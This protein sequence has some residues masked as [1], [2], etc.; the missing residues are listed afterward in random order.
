MKNFLLLVERHK[1]LADICIKLAGLLATFIGASFVA[2]KYFADRKQTRLQTEL[3]LRREAY[4]NLFT[5]IPLQ[6]AE[7]AKL[8]M[9]QDQTINPVPEWFTALGRLHLLANEEALKCVISRTAK[10]HLG[11]FELSKLKRTALNTDAFKAILETQGATEHMMENATRERVQAWENLWAM[12]R[13]VM[14]D[15]NAN[16][17][18][19]VCLARGEI[20]LNSKI[21]DVISAMEEDQEL[22]LMAFDDLLNVIR[23]QHGLPVVPL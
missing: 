3:N 9:L 19:L 7:I 16:Y 4:F 23:R 2:W 15:L 21:D 13:T 8:S 14:I 6:M 11:F 22:A 1:D 12:Y 18:K 5:A 17:R 10:Y 20:G